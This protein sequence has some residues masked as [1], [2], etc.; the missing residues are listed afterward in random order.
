M[1]TK[2][3]YAATDVRGKPVYLLHSYLA[4][5]L[6]EAWYSIDFLETWCQLCHYYVSFSFIL[7]QLFQNLAIQQPGF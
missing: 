3:N 4:R 2:F 1:K 6:Y 5:R 7:I